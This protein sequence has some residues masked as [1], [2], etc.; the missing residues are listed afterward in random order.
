[1]NKRYL[2]YIL[3]LSI[4][5]VLFLF[6]F[7]DGINYKEKYDT[8]KEITV[9]YTSDIPYSEFSGF[10]STHAVIPAGTDINSE[11]F[12]DSTYAALLIDN[13]D[14]RC[15]VAHNAHSRIYPA[16]MTKLMTAIIV[17]DEI[18]KGNLS[19][20]EEITLN[21]KI[22]FNESG[23]MTSSLEPGCKITVRNLMYGLLM[24]SYNDYAVILAERVSGSVESFSERMNQ[25]AQEIGATNSHF[26][27]P[28]GL[29]DDNHYITAYD[30]YLIV[31]E[32]SGYDII[33]EIDSYKSF[34][35]NYLDA[36]G[37]SVQV[38]ITPTNAYLSDKVSLPSNIMIETW[39]TGT[40]KMAG[41]CLTMIVSIDNKPY[42]LMIADNISSEDLYNNISMMFNLTK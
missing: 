16:S 39:K 36:A 22:T 26:V 28:H 30:M 33:Q 21:H 17:C 20:D 35:Y 2:Y 3:I 12:A 34:T 42:T 14:G 29:H 19:L 18:E 13:E 11:L 24:K 15:I 1:M 25:K 23:V 37:N 27:N 7:L 41:K 38:D 40:T 5:V 32:A 8:N 9:N 31:N 6:F 4:S 10:A